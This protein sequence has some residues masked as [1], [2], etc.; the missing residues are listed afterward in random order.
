MKIRP[1]DKLVAEFI[2]KKGVTK[3]PPAALLPTGA[4]IA[5]EDAKAIRAH[6]DKQA[7]ADGLPWKERNRAI[8]AE[9]AR[10][11]AAAKLRAPKPAPVAI[12]K[13]PR[14]S[15][16][17]GPLFLPGPKPTMGWL[18]VGSLMVDHSYQR[19]LAAEHARRVA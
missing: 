17:K 7:H 18:P 3:C 12:S 6:A 14:A 11:A 15:A 2:R 13:K 5:P 1:E 9:K 4:T 8:M 10:A 16:P 19:P